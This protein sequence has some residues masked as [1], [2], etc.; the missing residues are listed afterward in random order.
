[1]PA[2][3]PVTMARFPFKSIC[4]KPYPMFAP[5]GLELGTATQPGNRRAGA[6]SCAGITSLWDG[7]TR[8]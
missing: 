6:Q 2:V 1:M 4:M 8:P 7:F 5:A 3:D